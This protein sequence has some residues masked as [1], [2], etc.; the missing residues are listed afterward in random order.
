MDKSYK[1]AVVIVTYNR[2]ELLIECIEAVK[3]QS[4]FEIIIVDNCSTD[5]TEKYL[6]S[7]KNTDE[8]LRIIRTNQNNGGAGGFCVGVKTVS[9]EADYILLIDDDA[10]LAVDFL[11]NIQG[12]IE[13]GILAYSGSVYT[14]GIIDKSHRRRL[15]EMIFLKK[16]D[17]ALEEYLENSF[18]YDLSSFCGLI[19]DSKLVEK[20]GYPNKDYFIWYD[21]TEYSLRIKKYSQIKNV[22]SAKINH[23][24]KLNADNKLTW[25]SYYGYR[26]AIAMGREHSK[27]SWLYLVYRYG[28]H[29]F[30]IGYFEV[31]SFLEREKKEYYKNCVKLHQSVIEDS[32]HHKMGI[33]D[34]YFPGKKL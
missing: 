23:K 18:L 3:K 24:T 12:E 34:C 21:D 31:K 29:V 17:V 7:L 5:E 9:K 30:R 11:E 8:R 20:I 13:P 2:C 16:K 28:Y 19:V 26:N 27:L 14:D 4:F 6:N 22:N 1:F 25:K 33:S 32:I 10:I 15:E